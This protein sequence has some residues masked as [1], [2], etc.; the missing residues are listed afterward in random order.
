MGERDL[1]TRVRCVPAIRF[2]SYL[3]HFLV[4]VVQRKSY[5]LVRIVQSP[6][7]GLLYFPHGQWDALRCDDIALPILRHTLENLR[8]LHVRRVLSREDTFN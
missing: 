7:N 3:A 4:R 8:S 5:Q 2:H 1:G 6:V